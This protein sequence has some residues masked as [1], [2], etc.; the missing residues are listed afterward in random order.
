MTCSNCIGVGTGE[1]GSWGGGGGVAPFFAKL[2]ITI[3]KALFLFCLP[4]FFM[5]LAPP[6]STDNVLPTPLSWLWYLQSPVTESCTKIWQSIA[7]KNI[8]QLCT[9]FFHLPLHN[10][11][12]Y[13]IRTTSRRF[14]P[15]QPFVEF[16]RWS[17]T[18]IF[19]NKENHS[20]PLYDAD[21]NV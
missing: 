19:S 4:R 18:V 2:H 14:I 15:N 20:T 16:K 12:K 13:L 10:L 17:T 3:F 11:W 8:C 5:S 7:H 9:I 21:E 6:P 1:G